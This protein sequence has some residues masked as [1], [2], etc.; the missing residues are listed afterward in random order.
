MKVS[1][2]L[3]FLLCIT[4]VVMPVVDARANRF[5]LRER[6]AALKS[7]ATKAYDFVARRKE[8]EKKGMGVGDSG[9]CL[10]F[11][12]FLSQKFGYSFFDCLVCPWPFTIFI[13]LNLSTKLRKH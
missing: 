13:A 1:S 11:C 8:K 7:P 10:A 4:S 3:S 9:E 12:F 6:S 2:N 5:V